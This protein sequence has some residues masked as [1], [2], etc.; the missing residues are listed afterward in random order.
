[1]PGPKD[2]TRTMMA[3]DMG[4]KIDEASGLASMIASELDNGVNPP[5]LVN[6][7]QEIS[8][9]LTALLTRAKQLAR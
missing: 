8:G 6:A 7:W 1:M 4:Q 2:Y 3:E 5:E 9:E